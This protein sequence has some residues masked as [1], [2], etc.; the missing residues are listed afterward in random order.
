MKTLMNKI[1]ISFEKE[2]G[3]IPEVI[4]FNQDICY[5]DGYWCIILNNK[6]IKKTHGLSWR[7]D[8]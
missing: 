3:S 5:A 4:T 2:L 7:I 6:T 8:K 1:I